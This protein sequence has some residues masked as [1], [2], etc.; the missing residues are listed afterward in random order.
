MAD[1]V[2]KVKGAEAMTSAA[3]SAVETSMAVDMAVATMA[4]AAME[5]VTGEALAETVTMAVKIMAGVSV[6]NMKQYARSAVNQ[7]LFR[8]FRVL[9]AQYTA[10]NASPSSVTRHPVENEAVILGTID[11][12]H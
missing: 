1:T 9:V 2:A 6:C 8:S 12:N 5:M 4:T 7:R 11:F 3:G 10:V